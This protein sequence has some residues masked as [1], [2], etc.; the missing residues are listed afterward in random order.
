MLA[1]VGSG[2]KA[3]TYSFAHHGERPGTAQ[4]EI[5]TDIAEGA[6]VNVYK[7][8]A[9]VGKFS[10]VAG[11]LTVGSVGK[12]TYKNNT[13]SEYLIT[14]QVLDAESSAEAFSPQGL[15]EGKNLLY[16]GLGLAVG[17]MLVISFAALAVKRR[18]NKSRN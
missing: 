4:F 12:V 9:G 18:K 11:N 17:L 8:D 13:M 16:F 2:Q 6:K 3:F 5:T 1:A 14:T 15:F 10:F 7:F